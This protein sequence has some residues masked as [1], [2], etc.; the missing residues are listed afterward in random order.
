MNKFKNL[1]LLGSVVTL[2]SC[3]DEVTK[4]GLNQNLLVQKAA[5]RIA[6]INSPVELVKPKS[7][8]TKSANMVGY[9]FHSPV[10][11]AAYPAVKDKNVKIGVGETMTIPYG[12][13]FDGNINLGGGTLIIAGTFS[14]GNI[15]GSEGTVIIHSTGKWDSGDMNVGSK[16]TFVN[17]SNWVT[18]S[19]NINVNGIFENQGVV[20]L[21][22]LNVNG[23][24]K[25]YN[26]GTI[27]LS[28]DCNVNDYL[29]NE[30][31]ISSAAT[32]QVNGSATLI[33]KCKLFGLNLRVNGY[34]QNESYIKVVKESAIDG[35]GNLYMMSGSFMETKDIKLNGTIS[36][37]NAGMAVVKY[38]GVKTANSGSSIT[39]AVEVSLNSTTFI[40]KTGCNPGNGEVPV[41]PV[42]THVADVTSPKMP[43]TGLQLSCTSVKLVDNLALVTYHVA[44]EPYGALLEVFDVTNPAKPVIVNQYWDQESD[45]NNVE[46]DTEVTTDKAGNTNRKVWVAGANK[47]MKE[48]NGATI[49]EFTLNNN[50]LGEYPE[51]KKV[52]VDGFSANCIE[53]NNGYL[54]ASA[55]NTGGGFVCMSSDK[56]EKRGTYA[57]DG[58]KYI[59]QNGDFMV[60]CVEN[61]D[62]SKLLVFKANDKDL[63]P[64]REIMIGGITPANGKD[65]V[66]LVDGKA[67]V[68]ASDNGLKVFDVTTDSK[69]PVYK[70]M[71]EY[72][73][74]H[75]V[76][77]D[78]GLI[79]VA[80]SGPGCYVIREKDHEVLGNFNFKGSANFVCANKNYIFIA[81][82]IGGLNIV[83]RD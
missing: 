69:E 13:T 39:G 49:F 28:A 46:I 72:G 35:G 14:K 1:L 32:V 26:N 53:K 37:A 48:S 16:M 29:W 9:V 55:G 4:E 47:K 61:G 74:A 2:F 15:N 77:V 17:F 36:G 19:N 65:V 82:G 21:K 6:Y 12:T 27:V 83:K 76:A 57:I 70:F 20:Q 18:S 71:G 50:V 58:A 25:C 43:I 78:N 51:V 7:L 34:L 22:T 23:N 31:E 33:N 80:H 45:Y 79:Y 63:K 64:V 3:S 59:T 30:G 41:N 10:N 8:N 52:A 38:T 11:P 56:Y 68:C 81:N 75:G 54:Y 5:N 62:N 24:S 60:G 66:K 42:F 67:Y 40:E 44:G 73:G